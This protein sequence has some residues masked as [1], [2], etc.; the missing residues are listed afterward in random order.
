MDSGIPRITEEDRMIVALSVG[1]NFIIEI[2][3]LQVLR[4]IVMQFFNN[5]KFIDVTFI[6]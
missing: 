1:G 4:K 6:L 5:S 3:G 2:Y